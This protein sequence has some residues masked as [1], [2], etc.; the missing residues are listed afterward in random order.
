MNE[1]AELVM[2]ALTDRALVARLHEMLT[3]PDSFTPDE[4]R[5]AIAEARRRFDR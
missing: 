1:I 5:A 4:C 2:G 3:H